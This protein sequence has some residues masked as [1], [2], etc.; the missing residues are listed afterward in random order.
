M[1]I[2]K[3]YGLAEAASLLGI[4]VRTARMWIKQGKIK[5]NKIAGSNRWIVFESEIKR[6]QNKG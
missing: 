4:K 3:G 1:S 2:E 5:A 6:L